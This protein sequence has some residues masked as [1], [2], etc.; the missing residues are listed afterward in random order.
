MTKHRG[1]DQGA[2]GCISVIER[3][4]IRQRQIHLLKWDTQGIHCISVP[5]SKSLKNQGLADGGGLS[6]SHR[7]CPSL[8]FLTQ[9][10]TK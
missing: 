7:H 9:D 4:K 3:R 6:L 8:S 10:W 1:S 2:E 5:L